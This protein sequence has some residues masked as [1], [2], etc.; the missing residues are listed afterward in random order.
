MDISKASDK[1][2]HEGLLLKLKSNG[3]SGHLLNLFSDFLDERYQRT[4]LNGK[5]SN[6]KRIT[7]GVPQGSLL[8]P[9]LFLI[10][11]NDLADNI[12]SDV[13]LFA[14]DTS[15]FI[16]VSETDISTEVLNQDLGLCKIR[17][18]SGK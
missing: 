17:R 8:R 1:V 2:W 10:Y 5:S 6:W 13:K 18:I 9:F 7:A 14:D 3:I 4:V 11:I 16:V 15:M 12:M